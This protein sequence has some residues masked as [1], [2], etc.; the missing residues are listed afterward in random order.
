MTVSFRRAN[1]DDLLKITS[2]IT[3]VFAGEQKIPAE[4]I[5]VTEDLQPQWW[6]AEADGEIVGCVVMYKEQNEYHMGRFAVRPDLRGQHLG[7]RLIRYAIDDASAAGVLEII[8][9][10]RDITVH[11]LEAIG[12]EATGNPT[13]FYE[14]N[15][16]PMILKLDQS[17]VLL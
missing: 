2:L 16:T 9:E 3:T 8:C 14:G 15:V 13:P 4:L 12:A 17:N 7:S 6:C 5:P 10:A 11:I 1:A